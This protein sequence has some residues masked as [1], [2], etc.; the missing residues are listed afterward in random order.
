MAYLQRKCDTGKYYAWA[1]ADRT[2]KYLQAKI[3]K[4]FRRETSPFYGLE[5]KAVCDKK[6][7]PWNRPRIVFRNITNRTNTRTFIVALVPPH[8]FCANHGP[9]FVKV[10]GD[11][12]DEAYLLGI[13]SSIPLDWYVRCFVELNANFFLINPIPIPKADKN[14]ILRKRVIEISGRLASQDN[15]FTGWAEKVGVDCAQIKEEIKN[16]MINELDAVV[17]HLYGLTKSQLSHIFETFHLGWDYTDRL[18]K[19]LVHYDN[20]KK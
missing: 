6:E 12:K 11:E 20:W 16:D 13:L 8:V 7:M 1:D 2:T 10:K 14:C 15:R 3:I 17:A 18:K 9:Y 4:T 19:T 5:E